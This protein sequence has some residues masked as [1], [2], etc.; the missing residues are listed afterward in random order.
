MH[1]QFLITII[2]ILLISSLIFIQGC[3]IV[4]LP[5]KEKEE[6]QIQY[7]PS[8]QIEMSEEPVRSENGDM[9]SFIPKN[10]F[11]VDLGENAPSDVMVIAVNPDYTLSLVISRYSSNEMLD[12]IYNQQHLIGLANASFE[13]R[14]KKASGSLTQIGKFSTFKAGNLEFVVYKYRSKNQSLP[15]LNAIFKSSI[16]QIYEISLIPMNIIGLSLPSEAEMNTIFFSVLATVR[17]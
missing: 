11:F 14:G 15:S 3:F 12:E 17:Y 16:G 6:V 7:I 13:K 2:F 10:W 8:P 9:I 1:K 5:S 4:K